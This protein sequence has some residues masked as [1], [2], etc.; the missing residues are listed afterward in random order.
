MIDELLITHKETLS[1][2]LFSMAHSVDGK[3]SPSL[4]RYLI[5]VSNICHTA[6]EFAIRVSPNRNKI[7]RCVVFLCDVAASEMEKMLLAPPSTP[8]EEKSQQLLYALQQLLQH[9]S[10]N[11]E[12]MEEY[13][14]QF[15]HRISG[16]EVT[17]RP[18]FSM[19]DVDVGTLQTEIKH[20]HPRPE[21][22]HIS[23]RGT[24]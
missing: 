11:A 2:A 15:S 13:S 24:L 19:Q 7:Y 8:G 10:H 22:E 12:I 20:F 6:A 4:I 5:D 9:T 3:M 21:R 18:V 14:S 1:F 23:V 17:D 16:S